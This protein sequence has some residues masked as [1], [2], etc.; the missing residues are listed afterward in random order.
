MEVMNTQGGNEHWMPAE[1]S[2]EVQHRWLT[3]TLRSVVA[4]GGTRNWVERW[5]PNRICDGNDRVVPRSI[6]KF[7]SEAARRAQERPPG[8]HRNRLL[9]VNDAAEAIGV[10]GTNRVA[11]I[12]SIYAGWTALKPSA[13]RSCPA[14]RSRRSSTPT[15]ATCPSPRSRATGAP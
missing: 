10:V 15:R 9:S 6:L 1:P 8:A 13:A 4:H 3:A 7:F 2:T 11:E 14:P 5:I 12:R